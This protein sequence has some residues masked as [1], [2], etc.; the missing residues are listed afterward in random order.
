MKVCGDRSSRCVEARTVKWNTGNHGSSKATVHFAAQLPVPRTVTHLL[1]SFPHFLDPSFSMAKKNENTLSIFLFRKVQLPV[2]QTLEL[3]W[4]LPLH[5]SRSF[6]F[7]GHFTISFKNARS[8]WD[9]MAGGWKW[10]YFL[11]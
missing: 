9:G 11:L 4:C 8:L 3:S 10:F 1:L 6:L 5:I 2:T 7:K